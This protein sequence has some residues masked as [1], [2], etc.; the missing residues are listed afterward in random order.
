MVSNVANETIVQG[1]SSQTST[2]AVGGR[3]WGSGLHNRTSRRVPIAFSLKSLG[4]ADT[5]WAVLLQNIIY[6]NHNHTSIPLIPAVSRC[7]RR[8]AA[9]IRGSPAAGTSI[10][11]SSRRLSPPEGPLPPCPSLTLL[12]AP[13]AE[14]GGHANCNDATPRTHT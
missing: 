9:E 14:P 10:L 5:P 8:S 6:S 12:T 3:G 13:P 2:P 7:R 1:S 4:W 11:E